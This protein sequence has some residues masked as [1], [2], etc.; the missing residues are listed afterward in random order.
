MLIH[1]IWKLEV[2]NFL[3]IFSPVQLF[4]YSWEHNNLPAYFKI[5]R[6]SHQAAIFSWPS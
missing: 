1:I 2:E 4:W 5:W 6:P 3:P